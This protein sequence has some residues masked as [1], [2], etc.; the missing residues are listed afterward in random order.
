M[1]DRVTNALRLLQLLDLTEKAGGGQLT[2]VAICR[3]LGFV[4]TASASRIIREAT[5]AG[6]LSVTVMNSNTRE[7]F[8]TDR[9][10]QRAAGLPELPPV[11]DLDER[12]A[13]Q[14]AARSNDLFLA[15]LAKVAPVADAVDHDTTRYR[16]LPP[17]ALTGQ[18]FA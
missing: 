13:R 6:Y 18:A 2:N 5:D 15:A 7:M 14:A 16:R 3:A 9:G 10:R 4:S 8:L 11:G 1:T 17:P 12:N